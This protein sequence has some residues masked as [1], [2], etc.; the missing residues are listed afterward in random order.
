MTRVTIRPEAEAE[1][2]AA[3]DWYESKRS[4]LGIRFSSEIDQALARIAAA[5]ESHPRWRPDRGY[6]KCL[7]HRFPF[8]IFFEIFPEVVEV[9]AFAH[10]SRRPGYWLE[11]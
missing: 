7:V 1:L 6:R 10:A 9:V 11:R 5:A 8:I 4:G 2:V 3:A